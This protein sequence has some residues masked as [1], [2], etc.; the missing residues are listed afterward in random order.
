M[1]TRPTPTKLL[2]TPESVKIL[3]FPRFSA[4]WSRVQT[5]C[6]LAVLGN[7]LLNRTFLTQRRSF[8]HLCL[9]ITLPSAWASHCTENP[10]KQKLCLQQ[11]TPE[12][13]TQC[14]QTSSV[15]CFLFLLWGWLLGWGILLVFLSFGALS[16]AALHSSVFSENQQTSRPVL[17]SNQNI[18]VNNLLSY[19]HHDHFCF[20]SISQTTSQG[21]H[22]QCTVIKVKDADPTF[23]ST[24]PASLP[25]QK[26]YWQTQLLLPNLFVPVHSKE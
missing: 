19:H 12:I 4:T 17:S 10:C 1:H 6:K 2:F 9:N 14:L 25:W 15:E 5:A 23:F 21:F 3:Y 26:H 8:E 11:E 24:L 16:K 22:R 7:H 13:V 18:L 20:A